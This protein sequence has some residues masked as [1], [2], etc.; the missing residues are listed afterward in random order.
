MFRRFA[1]QGNRSC[2]RS[3]DE[4]LRVDRTAADAAFK[5]YRKEILESCLEE[6]GFCKWKTNSYVRRNSIG[7]LEYIDL[8]KEQHGSRTFTVN[9][10][11]M[12]LYVPE[13]S[14]QL[15]LG[16]RLGQ[17]IARRDVWWDFADDAAARRSFQNV[18]DA[19]LQFLL[20][21]FARFSEEAFYI[22][23]LKKDGRS[24]SC[25][26]DS[27]GWLA[28]VNGTEE[29]SAMIQETIGRLGLPRELLG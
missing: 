23:R 13:E 24:P 8:Q 5:K 2:I 6:Q 20:P 16:D 21:W 29:K 3:E 25:G 28:A 26:Y 1:L 9:F 27:R 18:A 19:V 17:L 11:L 14:I 12:P 4:M 22:K 15:G 7:L 10:A